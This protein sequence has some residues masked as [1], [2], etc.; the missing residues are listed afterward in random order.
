MTFHYLPLYH[1]EPR[2]GIRN[3]K[4][5]QTLQY[6]LLIKNGWFSHSE[7]TISRERKYNSS[8]NR[9]EVKCPQHSASIL[10]TAMSHVR[11]K[12]SCYTTSRIVGM[13]E[14]SHIP[15]VKA[16]LALTTHEYK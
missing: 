11:W 12:L 2:A 3:I 9:H 6:Y 8:T 4:D 7:S 10:E 14:Y 16:S 1:R 15:S 5:A 13:D